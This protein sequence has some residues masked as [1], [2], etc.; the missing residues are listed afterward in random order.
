M[1]K[2]R[3]C[4][5]VYLHYI[6]LVGIAA[7]CSVQYIG[8]HLTGDQHKSKTTLVCAVRWQPLSLDTRV[9]KMMEL[10][11]SV[12]G[13]RLPHIHHLVSKYLE[14]TWTA[15]CALRCELQ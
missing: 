4:I 8:W 2:A 6:G 5:S 14:C 13:F 15:Q 11:A 10:S 7:S 9:L 1:G 3:A 12:F